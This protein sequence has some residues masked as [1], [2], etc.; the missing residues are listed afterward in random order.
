ME[1]QSNQYLTMKQII[2]FSFFLGFALLLAACVPDIAPQDITTTDG[3]EITSSVEPLEILVSKDTVDTHTLT[4]SVLAPRAATTWY[5]DFGDGS[6]ASGASVTHNYAADGRYTVTVTSPDRS[7]SA[8]TSVTVNSA[9]VA[10]FSGAVGGNRTIRLNA[11]ASSDEGG[12]ITSYHWIFGDGTEGDGKTVTHRYAAAGDYDVTLIVTDNLG[13]T[14]SI[15]QRYKV[16]AA[17][18]RIVAIGDS[19]TQADSRHNSYRYEL[20]KLLKERGTSFDFVG[21]QTTNA[22]G[23]PNPRLRPPLPDGSRFDPDNEGHWGWRADEIQFN[24]DKWLKDYD[25]DIALIHIGTNDL[26]KEKN[27]SVEKTTGEIRA[28]IK[29]LRADNPNITILLS[30]LIPFSGAPAKLQDLNARIETLVM[31]QDTRTSRLFFVDQNT[32]YSV[33]YNYDGIHPNEIGERRM[34]ETWFD[35]LVANGLI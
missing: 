34:A 6:S 22:G 5:W 10:A 12:K 16:T 26:I 3:G 27:E 15:T 1:K 31:E 4:F 25:A 28:I 20:W 11:E 17:P 7:A 13:G 2:R 32:G 9:P 35:A 23:N 29:K 14:A 8:S 19:I 24:I 18:L 21:S 30:N 33:E